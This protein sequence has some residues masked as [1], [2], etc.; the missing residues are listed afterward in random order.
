[1]NK[2]ELKKAL[3]QV[4]GCT[5]QYNGWCCGTC[6]FSISEKFTNKDWQ[7][8][9]LIRGDY[10]EKDLT[11]LPKDR[12]ESYEKIIKLCGSKVV[13]ELRP[14]PIKNFSKKTSKAKKKEFLKDCAKLLDR[15]E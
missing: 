2:A 3:K 10:E 15:G 7:L 11:N 13:V 6:F 8:V 4:T 9:L 12:E 14:T 1:M 5:L